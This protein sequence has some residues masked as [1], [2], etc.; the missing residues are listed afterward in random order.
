MKA[1]PSLA[2]LLR[3]LP[4]RLQGTNG[5]RFMAEVVSSLGAGAQRWAETTLGWNRVTIRKGTRELTMGRTED[6]RMH[7]RGRKP[8]THKLPDIEED[9][10]K[11]VDPQVQQE[12]T[13]HT[14]RVFRRIT[15]QSVRDALIESG[16]YTDPMLP[17]VRTI[18]GMLTDLGYPPVKVVKSKPRK[19]I[20]QTDAIFD[21]V[22]RI[23][24]E[25]DETPGV[26]RLSID[27]K[28]AIKVG[29]FSRGGRNRRQQKACDHDFAPTC[30]LQLV[31]INLPAHAENNFYFN[32]SRTTADFIV[33]AIEDL[34]P[35]L[36]SRYAPINRLVLNLDNGP[37]NH[38]RRTQF[39]K[40]LVDFVDSESIP[41]TMAYYPPYHSKYNPI[42][43]VW[44][45]LEDYWN[46]D[47]LDS[48]EKVLG[49]AGSMKWRGCQPYV[50]VSTATYQKGVKLTPP[51]MAQYEKRLTRKRGLEPW[52]V[53]IQPN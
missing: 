33:D 17:C 14:T 30:I 42:E 29:P 49:M 34:W 47:L 13:F 2:G 25:A 41:I 10:K 11:L 7:L 35:K 20:P 22:H 40:R 43:R 12:Y 50:N 46:G 36:Q 21:E 16:K 52:S 28:A 3:E 45:V 24:A 27:A 18:C 37:E 31:G 6:N 5:R 4:R 32:E 44:G 8:I 1:N 19:K 51:E 26:L 9:I 15:A 48:R 38:S 39:V 53:E 23:N